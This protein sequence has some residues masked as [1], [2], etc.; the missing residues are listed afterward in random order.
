[1]QDAKTSPISYQ[2]DASQWNKIRQKENRG[3]ATSNI[4]Q[5]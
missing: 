3:Y 1:M 4:I 5:R 2:N